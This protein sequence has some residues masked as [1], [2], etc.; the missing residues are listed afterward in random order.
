[1]HIPLLYMKVES[2]GK[3]KFLSHT[4]LYTINGIFFYYSYKIEG[5]W[6]YELE[7]SILIEQ[8]HLTVNVNV[9]NTADYWKNNNNNIY[10]FCL[11]IVDYFWLRNEWWMSQGRYWPMLTM[12]I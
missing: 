6:K 12:E 11:F 1:M 8:W 10:Y 9:I 3:N 7:N 5:S 4:K 2:K